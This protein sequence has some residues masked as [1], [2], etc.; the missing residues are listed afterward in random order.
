MLDDAMG[1]LFDAKL[2]LFGCCPA[3]GIVHPNNVAQ[4]W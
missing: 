1:L 3:A 4:A 2:M